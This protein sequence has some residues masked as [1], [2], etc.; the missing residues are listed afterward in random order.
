MRDYIARL[1]AR[2]DLLVVDK[3]IDPFHE[4]AAVTAA[5]QKRWDKPILFNKVK[6]TRFPVV[7]N[8]YGSRE[9]LAEVIGIDAKDF[10]RQWSNLAALGKGT[11]GAD[12][13]ARVED[14]GLIEC[15]LSDLPL[16]TYSDRDAAPY[17][18]SAMFIAKDPETGVGNL[19]YH[20]SM[21]VSDDE[22]RCRL[23]PRHHLTIYHE[24]AEKMGKPLEAAMLIGAPATSFL[25]AAAPLPYDVDELEVAARLKGAPIAMRKCKY[26][27]LEVP[28]DTEI[29]IEGRFLPNERRAEGPFGEFMGYYVPEGPNAVFEVLGVTVR[30]DAVF[31]SIL[32]GSP[33]EVLT[34]E[35]SVSANIYQRLSAALPGI[36]DVTCQPFVTHAIIKIDPQFEGHARQVMLATIGAEPIWAKVI[37]VVDDDVN[38]YD[39]DDVM[40][41]ILTRCRPDKDMLIIPETPSFYRDDAKDHWGRLLIDATKPFNRREEFERKK[42]RLADTVNLADWFPNA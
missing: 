4:L 11:A 7:T 33:E 3:E 42:I 36:L 39:M 15:K 40:W 41:A 19:S 17:F 23:A 24:K 8:V 12:P 22:L 26:I 31:H 14:D 29:V 32:C 27:D 9:R 5:A 37:T 28:A 18:T 30:R 10:C 2:G 25:T 1:R 6:G 21:Y 13:F 16:I 38:I 35:L 34:L 20:R